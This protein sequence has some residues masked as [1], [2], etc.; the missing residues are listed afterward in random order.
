MNALPLH[1]RAALAGMLATTAIAGARAADGDGKSSAR[2][3]LIVGMS[4][5]PPALEPVLANHTAT[6]RVVPQ[7]FDTLI[8]FDHGNQM[9]LRPALAER[10][11]RLDARALKVA[12]RPGVTFHDGSPFTAADVAFSFSPDH[13][14]GPDRSG[15]SVAMQTLD[16]LDRVE[17][18]DPHTVIIHAKGDDA[19]LEQRLAA[20]ASEI[21]SQ[22]AFDA[23]GSWDRWAAA[24]VGTGPY[25]LVEQK[26]DLHVVL[27]SHDAYWGGRPPF[28][29]VEF[30]IRAELAAR[31]NGLVAGELDV[32]TDVP[33]DQFG[34]IR[35]RAQLEIVGGAVQNV[36]FLA[37]DTG[38]PVL[39]DPRVRRALSLAIDRKLFVESL[40]DNRVPVPNGFQLPSFGVGYI[41]DA[42][43][44]AYDPDQARAL[45]AAA[46]YKGEP[47]TYR[48]LGN[49]Y[50]N[51]VSGAQAMVEMWRAVGLNVQIQMMEN[52]SQIQRKPV[53]AIYDS[54]STAIFPDHLGHAWREFGPNGTLPKQVGIWSNAE[55]FAL[56]ARLQDTFDVQK[57]RE[58]VRRMLQIIDR[59]DPPC[60]ILHAS[61]QFYGKRRDV[62]WLPGQTLDLNFGPSN[63]A[64]SRT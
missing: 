16:R 28:D 64:L 36:R 12:L 58:I 3:R 53:R 55:Y 47:I 43:A 32:V 34:D 63:Q 25:R 52:F 33:P 1:R 21:V 23:A 29:G 54:S 19:L 44:L 5:F 62:P 38:D 10:W 56:G 24:P 40:W 45:L 37:I 35:K 7:M 31:V 61:G 15:R 57:R 18:V 27:A 22:R 8:A 17:V 42:P 6:R 60:I 11:E 41:E 46:Q 4:G 20:W 13:L 26:L 50:T 9:A 2:R 59:D 48:L 39:K 30:R 51:Q 49:Y 14:L